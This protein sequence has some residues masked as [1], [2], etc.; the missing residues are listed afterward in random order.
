MLVVVGDGVSNRINCN[1][2]H[3]AEAHGRTHP[4]ISHFNS[5][6]FFAL[7]LWCFERAT[8]YES[9]FFLFS[10]DHSGLRCFVLE[11]CVHFI[12][13]F[14]DFCCSL[15]ASFHVELSIVLYGHGHME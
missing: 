13:T 5:S 6:R 3:S 9:L 4:L 10:S 1:S 7:Y 8:L 15:F 2:I 12:L 11:I 14:I